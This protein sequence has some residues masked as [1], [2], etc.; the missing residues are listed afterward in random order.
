VEGPTL[1]A[2][3]TVV[4]IYGPLPPCSTR[5]E[6]MSTVTSRIAARLDA[7]ALVEIGR[8]AMHEIIDPCVEV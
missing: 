2:R 5:L 1:G 3:P 6:L 4:L 7:T 8:V